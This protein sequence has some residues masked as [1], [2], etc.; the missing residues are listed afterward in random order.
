MRRYTVI[1][2][3]KW[4]KTGLTS[5]DDESHDEMIGLGFEYEVIDIVWK[6]YRR[7]VEKEE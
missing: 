1:V 5:D 6:A 7:G 3:S 2:D 4:D